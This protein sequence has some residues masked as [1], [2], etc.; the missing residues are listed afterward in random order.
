M[1]IEEVYIPPKISN[2]DPTK[3]L[4]KKDDQ[5]VYW[6]AKLKEARAQRE[7]LQEQQ[8]ANKITSPEE[9]P[10]PPFKVSGGINIGTIDLQEQQRLAR[11]ETEKARIESQLRVKEAMEQRDSAVNALHDANLKHM[12]DSLG[13]QIEQLKSAIQSGSRRDIV[14]EIESIET[15]ASRLGLS[16][17]GDAIRTD[18]DT[19]I[20]LKR[21]EQ[22][23]KREDRKFAL[24]MK[25]D[26]RLW[27]LELKKLEQSE[28]ESQAKLEAERNKYSMIAQLPEQLGSTIAKG[29]LAGAG[30]TE[31]G[32]V[33]T[34]AQQPP[35]TKQTKQTTRV[36]EA[37]IGEAGEIQC[38]VCGT[39]VG[40]APTTQTTACVHCKQKF[41]IKRYDIETENS[42]EIPEAQEV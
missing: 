20:A 28:R 32:G 14:S 16:R 42:Q 17:S 26:E 27:Q 15:I 1:A 22:E 6:E 10:E 23:M 29:L 38:P 40:I 37:G 35:Q 34:Q 31:S 33:Q 36:I 11:E 7:F 8:M 19:Q 9:P 25:K 30:N 3:P 4:D 12:Q 21:L 13:T 24:D 41:M 2:L 5:V 39:A 18:F